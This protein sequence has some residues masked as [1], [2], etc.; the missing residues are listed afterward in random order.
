MTKHQ[1]ILRREGESTVAVVTAET[2][3]DY[4]IKPLDTPDKIMEGI[5][6]AVTKWINECDEGHD[7]WLISCE[8]LNIGDLALWGITPELQERLTEVGILKLEIEIPEFT[9]CEPNNFV[10][11]SVLVNR[12]ELV[13]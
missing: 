8:D 3:E 10:F 7:Q 1:F 12:D 11:D 5:V 9:E 2:I 4:D 13:R 6:G